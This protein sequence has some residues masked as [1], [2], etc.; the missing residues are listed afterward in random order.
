MRSQLLVNQKVTATRRGKAGLSMGEE[1]LYE[2]ARIK[3]VGESR[4]MQN[5]FPPTLQGMPEN[6]RPHCRTQNTMRIHLV[7]SS[8]STYNLF[9][10][11]AF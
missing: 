3:V 4:K 7:T 11:F 2:S 9:S 10:P 5:G 8:S 6:R 1:A